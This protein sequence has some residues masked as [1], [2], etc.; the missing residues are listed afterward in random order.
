[1]AVASQEAGSRADPVAGQ[2]QHDHAGQRQEQTQPGERF[3]QCRSAVSRS[4]SS[5]AL[6]PRHGHDQ[7]QADHDL[8]GRDAHHDQ[9]EHLAALLT[10]VARERDQREVAGVQHQLHRQQ[11]DQRAA[12][13]EH[14]EHADPE[15]DRRHRHEVLDA[16]VHQPPSS[17]L[18]G[19][20]C[21]GNAVSAP[22]TAACSSELG[23]RPRS[24]ERV[25][26]VDPRAGPLG[27]E[28]DAAHRRHQ[29]QDRGGLESQ[30]VAR[31]EAVGDEAG[32]AELIG[33]RRAGAER[34]AC[35]RHH[36]LDHHGRR[37]PPPPRP[38]ATAGC[39]AW[40]RRR[41]CRGRRSRTGT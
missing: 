12:A 21:T 17:S 3:H 5:S 33:D 38:A 41:G 26:L 22:I 10:P 4:T 23:L 30:Q 37:P 14:A 36:D 11:Q 13:R 16:D 2:G 32:V 31:E 29:Q 15:H 35:D 6:R 19:T 40:A 27:A 24:R 9:R 7:P 1:M 25:R 39:R 20:W 18:R 28:H 34:L 8:G